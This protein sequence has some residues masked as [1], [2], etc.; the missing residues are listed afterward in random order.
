[1]EIGGLASYGPSVADRSGAP[2]LVDRILKGAKAG[3][4]P[5]EQPRN[6]SWSSHEGGKGAWSHYPQ[7][8]L[9]RADEVIQ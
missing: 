6:L 7:T 2:L 5:I 4:L 1:V 9:L 3:D 8:L